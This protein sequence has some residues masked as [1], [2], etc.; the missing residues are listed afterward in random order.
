VKALHASKG[1]KAAKQFIAEGPAAL[2]AALRSKRFPIVN[3]YVTETGAELLSQSAQSTQSTQLTQLTQSI[4]AKA[5]YLSEKV[6]ASISTVESAQGVLAICSSEERLNEEE[7]YRKNA[8]P[9][10]Y[11][12]EVNDPG[13][14]GTIIRTADALG[15]AGVMLSPGSADPFSPKVV[16]ATAGSLWHIPLLREVDIARAIEESRAHGRKIYATDGQGA[17]TLPEV[18]G[19]DALWIFGNE[20]RGLTSEITAL[21]DEVVSI[22]MRGRAESLNLATAVAITL[23][24]A[25]S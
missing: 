4:L 1:R 13:N 23:F 16:R 6:M 9:L 5:V 24:H 18:S 8:L 25:N 14:L 7:I 11:C 12:F 3:L 15:A 22:P 20:A 19:E 2:E 10:I 21:A 17:K